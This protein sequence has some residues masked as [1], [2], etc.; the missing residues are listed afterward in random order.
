MTLDHRWDGPEDGTVLVLANSLGTSVRMWDPM[1]AELGSGFRVLRYE[2]PGHAP[3]GTSG[4]ESPFSFDD[5]VTRTAELLDAE[6]VTNALI[7]GVFVGGSIAVALAAAREDL[8]RGIVVINAPVRQPSRRFWTDRTLDARVSGMGPIADRLAARWFPDGGGD[9]VVSDLRALDPAGY[10]ASCA[11]IADLDITPV[12]PYVRVPAMVIH[13]VDD[14]TVESADADQLTVSIADAWIERIGSGG[15]LLPARH[16][17][18]IAALIRD[19]FEPARG[20]S[21]LTPSRLFTEGDH[22]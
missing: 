6:R 22:S 1:L 16:P 17:A 18:I 4:A 14:D 8:V 5:M 15:H 3:A 11:A 7:A 21:A 12:L 10:A 9:A 13:A 2:L 19:G 20:N